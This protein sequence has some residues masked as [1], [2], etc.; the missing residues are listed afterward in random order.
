MLS[1]EEFVNCVWNKYE[2][3]INF[4]KRDEFFDKKFIERIVIQ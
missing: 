1:N 2:A 3:Y 4:E